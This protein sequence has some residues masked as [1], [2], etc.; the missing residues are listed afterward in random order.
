VASDFAATV[1]QDRDVRLG[2]RSR[3]ILPLFGT[4]HVTMP[5]YGQGRDEPELLERHEA[6]MRPKLS[7]TFTTMPAKFS[8]PAGVL[9]HIT[10]HLCGVATCRNTKLKGS[11]LRL[12]SQCTAIYYC[13]RSSRF[14]C[15]VM[16]SNQRSLGRAPD[17][18]ENTGR[19]TRASVS[20]KSP[21]DTL[22]VWS[23]QR[24]TRHGER[25]S[26]PSRIRGYVFMVYT[27]NFSFG[28]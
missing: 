24:L 3:F 27:N 12:C 14:T 20:S 25:P 13:V 26:A 28:Q 11:P 16:H 9:C 2:K 19:S 7:S 4:I 23:W 10:D 6:N 18:S 21:D 15:L 17:V 1:S 22:S 8:S 5:C